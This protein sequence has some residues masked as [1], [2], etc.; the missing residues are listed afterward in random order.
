[1]TVYLVV[2][3]ASSAVRFDDDA[4]L[5]LTDVPTRLGPV[6]IRLDTRY[7][8]E[9]FEISVPRE[10]LIQV[11]GDAESLDGARG[12][13][14]D[15]G[16]A[17]AP[18]LAFAANA[19]IDDPE[20][21]LAFDTTPGSQSREMVQALRSWET[22][23]PRSSRRLEPS[24]AGLLLSQLLQHPEHP[25]L[26]RAV[27]HYSEALKP[28]GQGATL[29]VLMHLWM[30]V[31]AL[32]K[33]AIRH[34]LSQRA[35]DQAQLLEDWGVPIRQLDG[36]ARRR[37]IFH[38][39]DDVYDTARGAS[40]AIEHSF[41]TFTD[42]HGEVAGIEDRLAAHVRAA[43]IEIADVDPETRAAALSRPY[44]SPRE[45][46]PFRQIVRGRLTA[47]SDEL[48]EPGLPYPWLDWDQTVSAFARNPDGGYRVTPTGQISPRLAPGVTFSM[49]SREI[50]GPR[51]DNASLHADVENS[52]EDPS[53]PPDD[54]A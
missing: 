46:F 9:G 23:L 45:S 35:V 7:S 18:Y 24:F 8:A 50:W 43:I 19:A 6:D 48:A 15:A 33:A 25:R 5:T 38:E 36:E 17:I 52:A 22:G 12:E 20:F 29:R 11:R 44:E 47:P 53:T 41:Q 21:V 30:A 26:H 37:L 10:L 49:T 13:F 28:W 39:D 40:D 51:Q 3:E 14:T 1:M 2:L 27:V 4:S 31:E 32:T 42:V 34:E 16:R 54:G